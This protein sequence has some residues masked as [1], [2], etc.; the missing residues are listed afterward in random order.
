MES[1]MDNPLCPWMQNG[2]CNPMC[3][4]YDQSNSSCIVMLFM[5]SNIKKEPSKRKAPS[6]FIPAPIVG[7]NRIPFLGLKKSSVKSKVSAFSYLNLKI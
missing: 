6:K 7:M 4:F 5:K 1:M 2:L 3:Q